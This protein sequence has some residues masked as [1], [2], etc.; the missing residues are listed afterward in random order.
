MKI[1]LFSPFCSQ[2]YGTVLQAFSLAKVLNSFG[3]ECEYI[4]WCYYKLSK[5]ERIKFVIRHPL[6][7]YYLKRNLR[8]NSKDLS[9]FFLNKSPYTIITKKN[10]LF[11]DKNIPHTSSKYTIDELCNLEKK[12]DKFIVGSDQTWCPDALYQYSPY[13][14]S[15]IKD[16]KK[17][18]SYACSMGTVNLPYP[19]QQ[20]LKKELSSFHKLS[21]REQTNTA[22]LSTLLNKSVTCV[23]DPT[24]L[25][26]KENWSD[27]FLPIE[28]IPKKYI[29]CYILGEKKCI[30]E[31]A[32][33]LGKKRSLP[34][35]YILTRP[36]YADRKNVLECVGCQEF[37]WLIANC[38][39]L[40]T[41][42]FHG[43]IFALNFGRNFVSFDKH[44]ASVGYDNGRLQEIL[45]A[46]HLESHYY[47]EANNNVPDE[48][49]YESVYALLD[50]KRQ[51]SIDYLQA[52][53]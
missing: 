41:D 43:T 4:D 39:Y 34:V 1:A 2:N 27:Y 6:Y 20:F 35:Y 48:I 10:R 49:N 33:K 9:Y 12:Y 25:L 38:E 19:F 30:S 18:M 3:H 15:F 24:L 7:I 44:D 29:L 53:L 37:L 42:S 45:S 28:N 40:V 36:T 46:F 50:E 5:W 16:T 26:N 8:H 17:K 11:C 13:Y 47:T 22:L 31:Y 14:L 21:C 52:S 51:G 32:E 23:L